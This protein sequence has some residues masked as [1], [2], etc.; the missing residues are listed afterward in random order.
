MGRLS[1]CGFSL[2]PCIQRCMDFLRLALVWFTKRQPL[3]MSSWQLIHFCR[4]KYR[5]AGGTISVRHKLSL[6]HYVSRE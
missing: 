2:H 6:T 5:G 3:I 4:T 1:M